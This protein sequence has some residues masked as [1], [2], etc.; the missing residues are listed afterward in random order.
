M[1]RSI[2]T[3]EPSFVLAGTTATWKFTYTTSTPLPKGTK[4]RFDLGSRGRP[5]DWQVPQTD[6]KATTNRI[7]MEIKGAKP[8]AASSHRHPE[9]LIVSFD[10]T[11]PQEMKV[12]ESFTIW[13]GSPDRVAE[14]G[15]LCQKIVQRKRPFQLFIDPKG[16][17][18]YKEP[19]LFH[20]DVKGNQLKK[21]RVLS[22]S[23]VMR[24]K[25]FDI[26]IRFEDIYGN[27]TSN[28]PEG[29]LI[30]LS[31]E[32]LRE[33]LNW[34]LFVPETGFIAIPNLYFNEPGTYRLQLK[35]LQSGE[36]FTSSPIHCVAEGQSSLYWGLLH[37]ETDRF[38]STESLE[39]LLRYMRDDRGLHFFATSPFDSDKETS[40]DQW[41]ALLQQIAE[42]N[43]EERFVSLSGFQWLSD[44][45]EGGLRQFLYSKDGKP[46]LRKKETKSNSLKK[47][48]KTS[49]PKEMLAIPCSTMGSRSP[50]DFEDY[51]PE[52][53]RVVEIYNAWGS[54]ELTKK[55]GNL[56]PIEGKKEGML[57]V[58]EGSIVRA[59]HR[60]CRFGFVAGGFDDRGCYEGLFQAD[61]AQYSAGLTAI[62]AKEQ[63]RASLL[64]ALHNRSCYATT[65][66][67]MIL[68]FQIADFPMG[69]E[70]DVKDRPGLAFN[71]H[72]TGYCIGT[73]PLSE[74]VLIRNGKPLQKIPCNGD[75]V[76]FAIDDS[77]PLH[78]VA[79]ESSG[80]RVP[81]VYYYLRAVQQDGHIAWSSPI[82]IDSKGK[83]SGASLKS[84]R[85]TDKKGTVDKKGK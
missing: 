57:E 58:A 46:I 62:L 67:R 9:T 83:A 44:E 31:Y 50:F 24:N 60:G 77:D 63:T 79:I 8:I 72:I 49:N 74:I 85:T 39:G 51:N 76:E 40:Q 64:E 19:E 27:L 75:K 7:W 1:R 61:Q 42:F 28:A 2:C 68:G 38:D 11:L 73:A 29:T 52:F 71:R 23:L 20:V 36:L 66:E 5:L 70:V 54:S 16:K 10:F 26:V 84:A 14:K 59:L 65:G 15:T 41:K 69:T 22:P 45:K 35:N 32:H 18:D 34:K 56:R 80:D 78:S 43:E 6:P 13:M 53:E 25:R 47:I 55:E 82:W 12:G 37:G 81:F 30:D 48:Y 4:V 21:I 3:A 33:N 17:G